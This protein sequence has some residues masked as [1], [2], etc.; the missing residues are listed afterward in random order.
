MAEFIAAS[1]KRRTTKTSSNS[2]TSEGY[3]YDDD[4]EFTDN[5]SKH[6]N[7]NVACVS[8]HPSRR[9]VIYHCVNLS[10]AF[11]VIYIFNYVLALLS[12]NSTFFCTDVLVL[13]VFFSLSRQ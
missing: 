4:C 1:N 6:G 13:L 5:F 11:I 12:I 7:E 9:I 8:V 2:M 3:E 10:F